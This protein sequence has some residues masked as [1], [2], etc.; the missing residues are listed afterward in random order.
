MEI[1]AKISVILFGCLIVVNI[2]LDIFD[3]IK[4]K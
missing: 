4:K 2:A 1:I 3:A